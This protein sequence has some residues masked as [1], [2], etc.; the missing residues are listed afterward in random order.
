MDNGGADT[1]IANGA[2]ECCIKLA[3][4]AHGLS[5]V[6]IFLFATGLVTSLVRRSGAPLLPA[7]VDSLTGL[8]VLILICSF[9]VTVLRS[10]RCSV[11]LGSRV[12]FLV[13]D[14]GTPS[15]WAFGGAGELSSRTKALAFSPAL[16]D[17]TLD[18]PPMF[19]LRLSAVDALLECAEAMVISRHASVR[20]S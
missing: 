16:L 3:F 13:E 12:C 15:F 18:A 10:V 1:L 17:V 20:P 8:R 14:S 19:A 5:S 11:R 2:E 6:S 4:G 9:V 7:F